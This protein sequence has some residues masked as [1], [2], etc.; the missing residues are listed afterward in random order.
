MTPEHH[1]FSTVTVPVGLGGKTTPYMPDPAPTLLVELASFEVEI[2]SREDREAADAEARSIV[3]SATQRADALV[4]KA[5]DEVAAIVKEAQARAAQVEAAQATRQSEFD[6]FHAELEDLQTALATR[7]SELQEREQEVLELLGRAERDSYEAQEAQEAV[8]H[9]RDQAS[10]ITSEATA[11]A[12]TLLADAQHQVDSLLAEARERA[13]EAAARTED[14][15][16]VHLIEIQVLRE[17]EMELLDRIARLEAAKAESSQDAPSYDD[18]SEAI[19]VDL[20]QEL[21]DLSLESSGFE[22]RTETRDTSPSASYRLASYAP[23]TEQLSTTAFRARLDE[24]DRR[25]RKRR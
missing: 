20:D 10:D 13:A 1:T 22:A 17:R 15:Q 12:E 18:P 19:E 4:E 9:A 23:L 11:A 24:K 3:E 14:I 2:P 25:G 7:S 5:K 21:A 16:S 8:A 6:R